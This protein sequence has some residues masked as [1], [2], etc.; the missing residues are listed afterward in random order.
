M[1]SEIKFKFSDEAKT[2]F[3]KP[4]ASI[5]YYDDKDAPKLLR[6][7]PKRPQQNPEPPEQDDKPAPAT[8]D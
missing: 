4:S 1:M 5:V 3:F 2:V 6:R 8:Q 7:V